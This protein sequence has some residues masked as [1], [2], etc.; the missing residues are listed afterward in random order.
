MYT[1]YNFLH[2]LFSHFQ[3]DVR[4]SAPIFHVLTRSGQRDMTLGRIIRFMAGPGRREAISVSS[5]G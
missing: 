1:W 2:V 4:V 3:R 5:S